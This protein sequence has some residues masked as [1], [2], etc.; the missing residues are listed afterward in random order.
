MNTDFGMRCGRRAVVALVCGAVLASVVDWT[1]ADPAIA[2]IQS[3]DQRKCI[4][5]MNSAASKLAKAQGRQIASCLKSATASV[6]APAATDACIADPSTKLV[7][8]LDKTVTTQ[9]SKCTQVPSFGFAGAAIA[10]EVTIEQGLSLAADVFGE[11]FGA[12]V[13]TPS[14]D[15]AGA[16]CQAAI[17]R[18]YPR[19]LDAT[20][21]AF[22]DCKKRG[23]ADGTIT[24]TADLADCFS[25]IDVD[26]RGKIGKSLQKVASDLLKRCDG[27]PDPSSIFPGRCASAPDFLTCLAESVRCRA[28]LQLSATDDLEEDCERFDNGV[29]DN[30]C[31]DTTANECLGENGGNNCSADAT[32][33]DEPEGFSCVCNPGFFGDGVDCH[34]PD[35]CAGENGGNNC[36]PD[37]TCTNLV[38]GFSCECNPGFSGD[39]VIC[40]DLDECAG[41]GGGNN[42]DVHAT[43]T[44]TPGGFVCDCI[45]GYIGSGATCVDANECIGEGGGNDCGSNATC[46]NTDPGFTCSCPP[47][48]TG[49]PYLSCEDVDECALGT[50]DCDVNATCTNTLFSYVCT[51]NPGYA[52]SGQVCID[53]DE[54]ALG[55]DN[56]SANATCSNEAGGFSCACNAGFHGDGVTC[57]DDNE[58]LGEGGGN[59]C[60]VN[61]VCTNEPGAF[62]CTCAAGY[63]GNPVGAICNPIAVALTSPVHG[64][65]TQS[66]SIGVQ[67]Q[68]TASPIS[69][70]SLTINGN[71]VAI[72]PNGT[73]ATT[74]PLDAQIIFNEVRAVLTQT[75]TGYK[76]RD[77]RVVI[78]GPSNPYGGTV[79]QSVGLRINDSGF[80]ALEPVLTSLVNFDIDS[81]MPVGTVVIQDLCI[82][83]SFLGCIG[84]LDKATVQDSSLGGFG[85]D[86][87]SMTNF[88]AGDI[89]L[90]NLFVDL[91][92]DLTITG[93]PTTCD[94]FSV[95]AAQTNIFGDYA[96]QPDPGNS[97]LIDVNQVG[98]VN[99]VFGGFTDNVDCGGIGF[100]TLLID[101][102]KGDVQALMKSNFEAFLNDPDGAGP[103]DAI[104]AQSIEDALG[105]VELV[106]PIGQAF[107]V[108]LTTPL[109]DI[110]EDT[111]GITLASGAIMSTLV[112]DPGSPHFTQTLAVPA[113]FPFAQLG[114]QTT[115]G[116]VS[117]DMAIGIAESAFNQ[118]FAAQVESGS[119]ASDI[120]ELDL[121]GGLQ[122][123]TA[124]LFALLMPQ[125]GQLDPATQLTLHIRPTL[126]PVLTGA[127]GP[128]G[129][130][131]ELVISHMLVDITSGPPGMEV[132]HGR[133]AVDLATAFDLTIEPGTG[134]L[135]PAIGTPAPGDILITLLDNPLGLDEGI[136]QA[137]I[138]ALFAPLLPSLSSAFGSFPLPQFFG[139]QPTALE[140]SRA[141]NFLGIFLGVQTP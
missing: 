45:A 73:F 87:D 126:A 122:P 113:S 117:F 78:V 25:A 79:P 84:H 96:L 8:A 138:P 101:L 140:V 70:V 125:F 15:A 46:T 56:C 34:E 23:L 2:Q 53:V 11:D 26:A 109:F 114:S 14:T 66:N 85:I 93:I 49:D 65:F 110:P 57:T 94:S 105:G 83:D 77:R 76:V 64:V 9:N 50:D 104:V 13:L 115:P 136:L 16:Q 38:G 44:N 135:V 4:L 69:S 81:L 67:G 5:S 37:A 33:T 12:V 131:G 99:V 139:I 39:G 17:S 20:L 91:R 6:L 137:V 141:G 132:L 92:V 80:D 24:S 118:I 60:S 27:L 62:S 31:V 103:Q 102:L 89:R 88:V 112:P 111:I 18:R 90:D 72:Q 48:S 82:Q 54:C 3:S 19:A 121:G 30:S 22:L 63:S 133:I 1:A 129:E 40:V 52:G 127:T 134:N 68:V 7:K 59:N 97:T 119:L 124:G 36:S 71:P 130:L 28:C 35:E 51:C 75:A 123:L 128:A 42:C 120:T 10:N 47:G 55:T 100:L 43:C 98:G 58:C 108:N 106:G 116:G 95:S 107:G 21:R 29:F 86:I 32:C 41:Q 61:A 74:I